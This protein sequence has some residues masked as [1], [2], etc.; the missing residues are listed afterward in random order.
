MEKFKRFDLQMFADGDP[1][2]GTAG[3]VDGDGAAADT[4]NGNDRTVPKYSEDDVDKLLSGKFAEWAKK[5][6]KERAKEEEAAREAARLAQMTEAE[7][8]A[9][10]IKQLEERL[11]AADKEKAI[12]AMTKQARAILSDKNIHVD[13][14]LLANLISEDADSTKAAVESFV[15]L[16]LAEV[17]KAVKEKVK[18]E[19]PKTGTSSGLT[20]EQIEAIPN[21]AERQRMMAQNAHLWASK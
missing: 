15:K 5:R 2:P 19:P 6:D 13:D 7:K 14:A 8:S 12:A 18:G 11:A 20:R 17:E 4:G 1:A 9:E 3:K 16:F 21:R 10:R